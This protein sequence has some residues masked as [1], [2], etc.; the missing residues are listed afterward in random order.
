M[1]NNQ[2]CFISYNKNDCDL[3][4]LKIM[5]D[6]LRKYSNY[7]IDFLIDEDLKTGKD[8]NVFMNLI[9]EVEAIIILLTPEYKKKADEKINSGVY[10][11]YK[12]ILERLEEDQKYRQNNLEYLNSYSTFCFIPII[13]S[14]NHNKSCPENIKQYK[15]LDFTTLQF[16]NK[17]LLKKIELYYHKQFQKICSEISAIKSINT[18]AV[19]EYEQELHKQLFIETK[20]DNIIN[21]NFAQDKEFY[22]KTRSFND[23]KSQQAYLFLGRKGCGKSTLGPLLFLFE[24]D[25][26][27]EH[28]EVHVEEINIEY[29]I[30]IIFSNALRND[31]DIIMKIPIFFKLVWE[32][33]LLYKYCEVFVNE[34]K[35]GNLPDSQE[36]NIASIKTFLYNINNNTERE[37]FWNTH[38]DNQIRKNNNPIFQWSVSSIVRCIEK[39]RKNSNNKEEIFHYELH[40]S[41]KRDSVLESIFSKPVLK[42]IYSIISEFNIKVLVSFDGFDNLF[43]K[44]RIETIN[45][46]KETKIFREKIEVGFLEGFLNLTMDIKSNQKNDAIYKNI[47]MCVTV[48]KDRFFEIKKSQR[49]SYRYINVFQEIKWTGIELSIMLRK[50]LELLYNK[51]YLSKKDDIPQNRLNSIIKKTPILK[52]LPLTTT[53]NINNS[54]CEIDTFLNVLRHTFCRPRDILIYYSKLIAITHDF[55]ERKLHIDSFAVNKIISET[56]FDVIREEFISEFKNYCLNIESILCKFKRSKQILSR[57]ELENVLGTIHFNFIDGEVKDFISKFEFLF[58]IGF[59]GIEVPKKQMDRYYLITGEIFCFNTNNKTFE[60]LKGEDFEGCNFIIHP[61]F[62]EFLGLDLS[63]QNRLVL[64]LTWEKLIEE[65]SYMFR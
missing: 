45:Y 25:K 55:N 62:C 31:L 1:K 63:N 44:F 11:E 50:R 20:H 7:S 28:I 18:T 6:Y 61:I 59:I 15:A 5:I 51:K 12:I 17:E 49:D 48:P 36:N 53:I 14:H 34:D 4:T 40:S 52:D 60:I 33:L 38:E 39:A 58:D 9:K 35:K 32:V 2:K 8:I 27:K 10:T 37:P 22:V 13:F 3:D 47:D 30:N 65:E 21:K 46:D 56:T 42:N 29:I 54:S 23:L 57:T 64:N 24:H 43:E 16:V 41:I 19:K 26:Y